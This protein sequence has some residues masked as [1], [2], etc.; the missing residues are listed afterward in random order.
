MD[1]VDVPLVE[2]LAVVEA[3]DVLPALHFGFGMAALAVGT[4]WSALSGGRWFEYWAN[5]GV[6]C[7]S[8]LPDPARY[9][10]FNQF[11]P[12]AVVLD[13]DDGPRTPSMTRARVREDLDRLVAGARELL[14]GELTDERALAE[15][16][17]DLR[18]AVGAEAIW[19]ID[20]V[21]A[22]SS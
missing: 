21:H 13:G 12:A 22:A 10:A 7:R 17:H 14:A 18:A 11:D 4:P 2:Q 8:V 5:A 19:S 3:C 15:Y 16:V 9:P 1:C 6:P 20:G